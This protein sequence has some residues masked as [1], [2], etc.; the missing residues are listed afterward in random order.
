MASNED[1]MHMLGKLGAKLDALAERMDRADDV[2]G[3]ERRSAHESRSV[4]HRRLDEQADKISSLR[5]DIEIHGKIDA[6]LRDNIAGLK[7]V[8]AKD[9]AP[10]IDEWKRIKFLGGVLSGALIAVGV[11]A[12][13]AVAWLYDWLTLLIRY[14]GKG[15]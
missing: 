9:V 11:T 2:F 13:A 4:I 10:T 1:I 5:T 12:A 14:L 15:S 3:E 8:V 6:Q 7:D